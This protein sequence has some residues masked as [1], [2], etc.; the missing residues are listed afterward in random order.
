MVSI[1][2]KSIR[3]IYP[4]LFLVFV[5]FFG[6]QSGEKEELPDPDLYA[7]HVRTTDFQSPEDEQKSF[8]VPEGFKVTLFASEPDI[9]KPINMEF[10]NR[11]RLWVTQSSEYPI[12]AGKGQ[13]ADKISILEDTDGDGRADQIDDFAS[14]LNIPIGIMPM[15]DG[16][17]AY[18][19]P[20]LYYF[21]DENNDQKA[22]ANPEVLLGPFG[23]NDTHGMV[24][25]LAR[26]YDGWIHA[27]HGF[28]N[29]STIAGTDGDSIT[30]TSG[31]TF[32]FSPDGE[33]VEQTTFGRVNPFG[34]AYD[35][36]GYLYSADCHSK[37]IYQLIPQGNYPHFGKKPPALGFA[38]EMM[39]YNLGSTAL[40]GL[41]LYTANNFPEEYQHCFYSGDV[42]TCRIDR[43][44]MIFEGST[45]IAQKRDPL[46]VS[47]DPWFRPVD[48]K[49]GP[50]GALYVADFYNK[51]IGHYEVPL[52]H[53]GRDRNSGRIWR[54][55]YEGGPTPPA[56]S[57]METSIEY[58]LGKLSSPNLQTRL[59]AA[60]MIVDVWGSA[61]V[62]TVE[63]SI[64]NMEIDKLTFIHGL[65]VLQ[66]IGG[67][68]SHLINRA[69]RHPD[70]MVQVH[71]I[72]ILKERPALSPQYQNHLLA[73]VNNSENPHVKRVSAEVLGHFT[74]TSHIDPLIELYR[75]TD[76]ADTHL[77]Y[78]AMLGIQLNLRDPAVMQQIVASTPLEAQFN[79]LYKAMLDIPSED[80]ARYILEQSNTYEL[81]ITEKIKIAHYLARS[82]SPIDFTAFINEMKRDFIFEKEPQFQMLQAIEGGIAA[83]G[84]IHSPAFT[85]WQREYTQ[86]VMENIPEKW[87]PTDNNI[88]ESWIWA[89]N[90]VGPFQL[91]KFSGKITGI[92]N[93]SRAPLQLRISAATALQSLRPEEGY[94]I[95]ATTY[96]SPS[97]SGEFKAALTPVIYGAAV[98]GTEAL[99]T[100]QIMIRNRQLQT[101]IASHLAKNTEGIDLLL[102]A[103][104]DKK[105]RIDILLEKSV[106]S[107]L[108]KNIS[109]TQE[110]QFS[111]LRKKFGDEIENINQVIATR[112]EQFAPNEQEIA[113]G[114]K[115]FEK[116]CMTCHQVNGKGQLIGPQ[117]DGIGNWGKNALIEKILDPNRNI[118]ESFRNFNIDMKD[119]KTLTGLFRREEGEAIVFADIN[120]KE[121][122]VNK[123]NIE[124]QVPTGTTLMPDQFRNT[125]PGADFNKL[126]NYLLSIKQ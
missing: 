31:N 48:V 59:N 50:D 86:T 70:P 126:M 45:P 1:F 42:V 118:S 92:F 33:R 68:D 57:L 12:A 38:P 106:Q 122:K 82:I 17:I 30:M 125:I 91:D 46:L 87:Q 39:D 22:D 61:A 47:K 83:R 69:L 23:H 53:E 73:S 9:T 16:A 26:G 113:E 37:P 107:E 67:L 7:Q 52:D 55:T 98:K 56:D 71:G 108:D 63:S 102:N 35:E 115:I 2:T 88:P 103:V 18:S 32:R 99:L 8:V 111:A 29:T 97:E 3:R 117:L 119:G 101:A 11:G 25:N 6:C 10:D 93:N 116:N 49:M 4:I 20:N 124:K 120:G 90:H 41:E 84:G 114:K 24:N 80:A 78:T 64:S 15:L 123:N 74:S 96:R 51:I 36:W 44:A 28:T 104:E 95:L 94:Q 85:K 66:R 19:I 72:R 40:A 121:F 21:R 76:N 109:G 105:I 43:N 54:I 60:D 77:K 65:W 112:I 14:D 79:V 5:C 110:Q 34:Y 100:S 27:C 13:G 81:G 62:E 58:Y 89:I 75:N